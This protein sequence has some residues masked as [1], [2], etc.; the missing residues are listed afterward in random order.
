V[1]VV[2]GVTGRGIV[3]HE[4]VAGAAR[5]TARRGY[6][7]AME[8][9]QG[10]S[11]QPAGS[12]G[13][14]PSEHD[15]R[16]VPDEPKGNFASGDD[17]TLGSS[18]V[19][20]RIRLR[21]LDGAQDAATIVLDLPGVARAALERDRSELV[22]DIEAGVLSDDELVAA[23]GRGGVES[24]GW[25]DEPLPSDGDAREPEPSS[26]PDRSRLV[27]EASEESFP[28]SDPPSYWGRET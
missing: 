8:A 13:E 6:T 18:W 4:P 3:E 28:A 14:P 26:T 11:A 5:T 12:T 7:R 1:E 10:R 9:E 16:S 15:E 25:T 17:P 2:A 20:R 19:R 23:L 27:E 21:T 24:D 22:V